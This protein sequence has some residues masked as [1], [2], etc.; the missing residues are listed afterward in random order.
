MV[1][2]GFCSLKNIWGATFLSHPK[3]NPSNIRI[4]KGSQKSRGGNDQFWRRLGQDLVR[5]DGLGLQLIMLLDYKPCQGLTPA[6]LLMSVEILTQRFE[7]TSPGWV[8]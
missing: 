5:Q 3:K 1:L 7:K 8:G 4:A 2:D 6:C